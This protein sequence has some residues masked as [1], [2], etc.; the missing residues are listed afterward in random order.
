MSRDDIYQQVV[1]IT[2][3][4]LHHDAK[5]LAREL[6]EQ[7]PFSKI[8]AVTR[9]G[10]IPAGIIA[11]ELGIR[12]VDTVCIASYQERLQAKG[13]DIL[14]PIQGGDPSWLIID[15][16]VDTGRTARAVRAM[17]PKGR[18]AALYAKPDGTPLVDNYVQEFAQDTWILFP[19]D[20]EVQYA[21]PLVTPAKPHNSN[22]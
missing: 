19:W 21:T 15:D 11:R 9:G 10:L 5:A 13:I 20:S 17:L 4:Q 18:F 2:W 7:G 14:K 12:L 1:A 6:M 22:E 16:L 8:I 3:S